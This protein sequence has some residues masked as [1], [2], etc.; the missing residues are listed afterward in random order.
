MNK[1][2]VYLDPT[3]ERVWLDCYTHADAVTRPA[4][5]VI[6][7]GGYCCVC[8]E[9]EGE[10]IALAFFERGYN[11]FVLNYRVGPTD[12]YP[13]QLIDASR[14]IVYIRDNS[15]ALSVD[16]ARVYAL[17][18]SA[19]GHLAGSLAV[20]HHD[21]DV[22]AV[23]NIPR[24]HNRPDAAILCYPVVSALVSTH[25]SSFENLLG[26]ATLDIG[27]E[28]L[29]SVSLE[30][31]VDAESAPLF[32]W[33]TAGDEM[34]PVDGSFAL[35]RTYVRKGLPVDFH[36]FPFGTHGVALGNEVTLADNPNWLQPLAAEWVDYAV[37]FLGE[38]EKR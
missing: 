10:P 30:F 22:L 34:V 16:P 17:G 18:F 31:N 37:R 20:L 11:S 2:R 29:S 32:I 8:H 6:P 28:L 35:A 7:G 33:H 5:L 36:L 12:H 25:V 4:M 21:P 24:G 1:R 15:S 14:A 3:D 27:A 9:R 23:L 26:V 38:I 19:G 13:S